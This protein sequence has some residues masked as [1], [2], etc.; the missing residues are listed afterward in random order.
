M[1]GLR[2]WMGKLWRLTG[3]G[4][5]KWLT[6][7]DWEKLEAVLNQIHLIPSAKDFDVRAGP[8]GRFMALARHTF[9][10]EQFA[11]H[12]LHGDGGGWKVNVRPG[13]IFEIHPKNHDPVT[14]ATEPQ[15]DYVAHIG[16]TPLT[17]DPA[18]QLTLAGVA[19]F[20]Y[21]HYKTDEQG[22]LIDLGGG[23]FCEV[24]SSTTE[25]DTKAFR[26]PD[27]TGANGLE[28]DYHDLIF[29][30]EDGG[31]GT[32]VV[33]R[34]H[35]SIKGAQ[36]PVIWSS[37]YG[38][39]EN[40]GTGVGAFKQHVLPADSKEFKSHLH[41]DGMEITGQALEVLHKVILKNVPETGTGLHELWTEEWDADRKIQ[42]RTL[43]ERLTGGFVGINIDAANAGDSWEIHGTGIDGTITFKDC[44]DV[45]VGSMTFTDGLLSASDMLG[46]TFVFG[47]CNAS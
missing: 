42:I 46:K 11:P 37:G 33:V 40:V 39:V 15:P 7:D 16:S 18:P 41:G 28:G 4:R 36:G 13:W 2:L 29:E 12:D 21:R 9:W 5:V 47:E 1:R 23:V 34:E 6:E 44:N 10:R 20:N 35:G 17:D 26:L 24:I 32:P 22:K 25:K 8:D 30:T 31:G 27:G 3:R 43:V 38:K 45:V 19:S 14:P